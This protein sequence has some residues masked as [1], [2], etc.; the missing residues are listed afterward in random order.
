MDDDLYCVW[1]RH[2]DLGDGRP[3]WECVHCHSLALRTDMPHVG[4]CVARI[5]AL[6][7]QL[8]AAEEKLALVVVARDLA[9]YRLEVAEK[10]LREAQDEN[11]ASIGNGYGAWTRH[12][13]LGCRIAAALAGEEKP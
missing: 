2:A 11:D 4:W 13:D 8:E 12:S 10:L 1:E 6:C 3:Y 5:R 7:K 9:E